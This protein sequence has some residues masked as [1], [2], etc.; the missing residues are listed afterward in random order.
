M[1]EH[2]IE[3]R[4][5]CLVVGTRYFGKNEHDEIKRMW[6]KDFLPRLNE[7]KADPSQGRIT[8]GICRCDGNPKGFEY[9]A[10]IA[11]KSF[12]EIPE[13]MVGWEIPENDYALFTSHGLSELGPLY[14]RIYNDWFP[15]LQDYERTEGPIFELYP[16]TFESDEST[17]YLCA[18]VK[19][20]A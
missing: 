20:K 15:D 19:K 11:V 16:E 2:R 17:L 18:P 9:L 7:I 3:H 8:Y 14:N 13:G 4:N 5:A 6:D 12:D 1:T 10:G